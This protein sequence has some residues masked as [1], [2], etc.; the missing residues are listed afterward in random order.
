MPDRIFQPGQPVLYLP[1]TPNGNVYK[2]EY[3]IVKRMS[4][5]GKDAY[6]WYH[7]GC[8]AACTPMKYLVASLELPEHKHCHK[9]CEQCLDQPKEVRE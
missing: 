5:N 1:T 8:T 3:G 2:V 9:G 7:S 6:V 4:K